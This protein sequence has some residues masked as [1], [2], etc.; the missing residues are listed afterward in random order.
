MCF[1][2]MMMHVFWNYI[3]L[4]DDSEFLSQRSPLMAAAYLNNLIELGFS[5]A[6]LPSHNVALGDIKQEDG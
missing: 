3:K 5:E 4:I 1:E 2:I 6:L